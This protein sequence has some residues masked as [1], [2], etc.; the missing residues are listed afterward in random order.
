[1]HRRCADECEIS[2]DTQLKPNLIDFFESHKTVF[3]VCL[4][5]FRLHLRRSL[6][7]VKC[8]F[9]SK[10]VEQGSAARSRP[11]ST[12]SSATHP[13][14]TGRVGTG[15]SARLLI[16][17][18]DVFTSKQPDMYIY[19]VHFCLILA[20][21]CLLHFHEFHSFTFSSSSRFTTLLFA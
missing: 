10:L 11:C 19:N 21:F 4:L 2:S 8:Y 18:G 1:M 15:S 7:F 5:C 9:Y 20:Y 14:V 13:P 3:H 12:S 17:N 6:W 16:S